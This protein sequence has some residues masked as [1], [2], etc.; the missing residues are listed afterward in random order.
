MCE[1]VNVA[2]W[3]KRKCRQTNTEGRKRRSGTAQVD[4]YLERW[5]GAA[6]DSALPTKCG[7]L[8]RFN[9]LESSNWK[10]TRVLLTSSPAATNL[11]F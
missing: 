6:A 4:V 9:R 11:I 5:R 1:S 8:S 2:R 3:Y 7:L 10:S